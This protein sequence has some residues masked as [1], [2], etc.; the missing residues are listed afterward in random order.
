MLLTIVAATISAVVVVG[1]AA[2]DVGHWYEQTFDW[3]DHEYDTLTRLHAGFTDRAF[4]A[5]LGTPVFD[6]RSDNGRFRERTFQRREYWVQTVSQEDGTVVLYAVTVCDG[7]FHPSFA[8]PGEAAGYRSATVELG[9]SRFTSVLRSGE[10]KFT[11]LDFFGTVATA[12]QRFL[13]ILGG[14]NP[15]NYKTYVWGLNDICG[16]WY[17]QYE[18]LVRGARIP[19]RV[20][21]SYRG[22]AARAPGWALRFRRV[23]PVNTYAETAPQFDPRS[24]RGAFQVGADRILTRTSTNPAAR[25]ATP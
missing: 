23:A 17:Q 22:V 19:S 8:I 1:S 2:L 4:E 18:R 6:R 14:G 13:E 10:S 15:T 11:R 24:L 9:V 5:A 3:R 25:V 16:D 12:N 20:D 21:Q 7:R